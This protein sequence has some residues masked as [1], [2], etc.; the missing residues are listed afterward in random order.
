MPN[1]QVKAE[2]GCKKLNT[3]CLYDTSIH[4]PNEN[5]IISY[6]AFFFFFSTSPSLR[7]LLWQIPFP[8]SQAIKGLFVKLISSCSI[9][10]TGKLGNNPAE[11]GFIFS[12][13][14]MTTFSLFFSTVLER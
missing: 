7:K 9:Y 13:I 12:T 1:L 4:Q 3:K 2:S 14:K 11:K 8:V 5:L 10:L 6:H